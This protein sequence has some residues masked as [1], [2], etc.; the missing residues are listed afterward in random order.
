[1]ASRWKAERRAAAHETQLLLSSVVR[2]GDGRVGHN[3][4]GDDGD[5]DNNVTVAGTGDAG[6]PKHGRAE[7]AGVDSI[8]KEEAAD[9]TSGA[10]EATA[11]VRARSRSGRGVA[12]SAAETE[13]VVVRL[14][15]VSCG[16]DGR[17]V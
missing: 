13:A 4:T 2:V 15:Y 9:K 10:G 16:S 7:D 6:H 12:T 17:I 8:S 5:G 11:V 1:M 14:V 3:H